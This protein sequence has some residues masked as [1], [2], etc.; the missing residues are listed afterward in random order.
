ML[1]IVVGA[2]LSYVTF[3]YFAGV[4]GQ[5][6]PA[7]PLL[8]SQQL[9]PE[10]RLQVVEAQDLVEK[11]KAED[12]QLNGYGWIDRDNGIVHIPIQRAMELIAE[13]ARLSNETAARKK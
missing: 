2:V 12:K 3:R 6:E 7:Y 8:Q 5:R 13:Q 9:P 11:R 1:L 10:P 4:M